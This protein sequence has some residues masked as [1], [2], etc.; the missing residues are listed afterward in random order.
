[1]NT[2][3]CSCPSCGK[4]FDKPK[5]EYNRRIA[6]GKKMYCSRKCSSVGNLAHFG[7][8]RNTVPPTRKGQANPF[9]YYLRN[10]LKRNQEVNIDL[11][12]L[13]EIW[14]KQQGICPYSGVTLVL[15]SSKKR[16]KDKRYN[17]SLDRIDSTKGYI[18]GNVQFISCSLNFMKAELTHGET[19]ELCKQIAKFWTE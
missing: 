15:N 14:D 3:V 10:C 19:V 2:V 6:L 12:Y 17:A 8:K 16:Y 18:K 11:N 1:M 7:E 5:N 9:S 13:K 4:T